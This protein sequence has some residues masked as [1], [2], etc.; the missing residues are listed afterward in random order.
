MNKELLKVRTTFFNRECCKCYDKLK[1]I[2]ICL[3]CG[4]RN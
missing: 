4:K 1:G 3:N 2:G